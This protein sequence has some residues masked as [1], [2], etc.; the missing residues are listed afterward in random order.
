[1]RSFIHAHSDDVTGVLSGF[2][3]LVLRG[4]LRR[5]SYVEGMSGYL[6]AFSIL[7]KDFGAHALAMTRWLKR[8]SL[9][10][11][12]KNERPIVYLPSSN[13][14]KEQVALRVL[15]EKP[16]EQGLT[17]VISS[18]EPC[19]SFDIYKNAQTK[20]LELVPRW[21]KGLHLYH[22]F[23]HPTFGFMNARI[24]TWFPFNIQFCLNGREWLSRELDKAEIG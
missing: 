13:T 14:N 18:V 23:I 17:A 8:A 24:Q 11:A 1:M 4:N 12:R 15:E 2:D 16:V 3:R 7:L 20:R 10:E 6:T 19:M 21:R 22:Y 5:L 9:E